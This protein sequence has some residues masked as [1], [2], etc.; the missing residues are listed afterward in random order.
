MKKGLIL[1]F[2]CS[3]CLAQAYSQRLKVGIHMAGGFARMTLNENKLNDDVFVRQGDIFPTGSFGMQ[4]W[5]ED[6][7][8]QN[9]RWFTL[10][11]SVLLEASLC[12][13]G[14]N[15]QLT[16]TL[17]NGS[18]TLDELQYIQYQINMSPKFVLGMGSFQLLLGPNISSNLYS[19][20][21]I[22]KDDVMKSAKSQMSPV[23]LGYE[24]GVGVSSNKLMFSVRY[25]GYFTPY[26][27]K[28]TLIPTVYGNT[29]ILFVLS[30]FYLDRN[31]EKNYRSI[32]WD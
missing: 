27:Q 29:Q 11:K 16:S 20:V 9:S 24:G 13:C 18:K 6:S 4:A 7:K 25:R 1:L 5:L 15:I 10:K 31:R 26:G 22:V 32:F 12:R 2:F 14:G 23:V 30:Y 8:D 17:P 19:G 21:N 3:F 28:T